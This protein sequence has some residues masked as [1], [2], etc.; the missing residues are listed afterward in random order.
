MLAERI[1]E[2]LSGESAPFSISV[3]GSDLDADDR[4]GAQIVEVLQHLPGS[5]NVRLTVPPRQPELHVELLPDAAGPLRPAGGGRAADRQ[6]GLSRHR[7]GGAQS[8]GPQRA[9]GGAHR[10]RRRRSAGGR[11]AAAARPR[12]RCDAAVGGRQDHDGARR[13]ASSIT[14]TACAARSSWRRPQGAD[15]AG[16]AAAAR[17]AIAA[18]V[19]L[20][21]GVYLRYGGAAEA[22]AAAARELLLHSAA[23]FVLIVLL[24][25]L[26]FGPR[27]TCCWCC[28]RC[29][30]R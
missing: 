14:R 30:A 22:Q 29:R 21:P 16:F 9:G 20:P 10:R 17:K 2:T 7:G 12:R 5:G 25:A 4:V 6:C 11:R 24:L 1:G 23:A 8:G 18:Q 27:G 26:A 19:P 13:A 15:Q 3:I 28:S